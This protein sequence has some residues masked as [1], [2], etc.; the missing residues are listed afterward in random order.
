M[1]K[2]LKNTLFPLLKFISIYLILIGLYQ[3]YLNIYKDKELDIFSQ[4][5]AQQSIWLSSQ[6]GFSSH[7]VP[8]PELQIAWFYINNTYVSYFNEGCNAVSVI[9]LFI[10]FI[11]AFYQGFKTFIFTFISV[12]GLH[13]LNVIRVTL[14]NIIYLKF[15]EYSKIGHDYLFPA[16]IYGAV[17]VLWIFW[18]KF[19]FKNNQNIKNEN[20]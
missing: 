17:V 20:N 15:P 18:I 5:V 6:L 12:I 3:F 1:F 11:F 14:L 4:K 10:A 7:L 8:Q 9:I 2:D 19:F 16:I 13:I